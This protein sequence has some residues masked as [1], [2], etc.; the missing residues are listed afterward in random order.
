MGLASRDF[1]FGMGG[2]VSS[3]NYF[4]AGA[5][6]LILV[7][8]IT[9]LI[10]YSFSSA[11][12]ADYVNHEGQVESKRIWQ[13]ITS[14]IGSIVLFIIIGILILIAYSIVSVIIA[15]IPLLGFFGRIGLNAIL[16]AVFGITFMSIF[17]SKKGIG[18]AFSEGFDFTFSKFWRIVLYGIVIGILNFV[19]SSL[20][21][22]IPSVLMGIGTYFSVDSGID[23]QTSTT[24]TLFFTLWF[25]IVL[26][27]FIYTQGLTQLSYGILYYNLYEVKHNAFLQEKIDQIGVND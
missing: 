11:Y 13:N 4:L 21:I 6:I 16:T 9:S 2:N 1:R 3:D 23:I 17:S 26:L 18:E 19:I 5:I 7:V 25:A 20:L 27:V 24:A 14:N 8:F 22:L 12:V 10:N 15:F